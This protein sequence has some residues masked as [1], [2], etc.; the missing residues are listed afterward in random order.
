MRHAN[1]IG[2][3]SI[4]ILRVANESEQVHPKSVG[5]VRF[6]KVGADVYHAQVVAYHRSMPTGALLRHV[7]DGSMTRI[8]LI[9]TAC[10]LAITAALSASHPVVADCDGPFPE[11]RK[12]V[13]TAKT[14]VI[15]DVVAVQRG[16]AWDP[17]DGGVSSRFTL[18]I[19]YILRGSSEPVV[20]INDLQTSGCAPVIGARL[21]DRI[22]IA[23]DGAEFDR[24]AGVNM[25]AWI[26]AVPPP[27]FGPGGASQAETLSVE[28][29]FALIGQAVPPPASPEPSPAP[30]VPS[31]SPILPVL[32]GAIL[33]AALAFT[34]ALRRRFAAGDIDAR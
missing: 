10:L 28:D 16:G 27:A 8:Q 34:V 17:V 31:E 9:V 14:I 32:I 25:V 15:G 24:T 22:A 33:V 20:Q 13:K 11:F 4:D 23:Y 29:A 5:C 12:L 3:K 7:E 2:S 6:A 21:G 18:Q 1:E 19:A 26:D 30:A